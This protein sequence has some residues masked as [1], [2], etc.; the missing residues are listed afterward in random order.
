MLKASYV[1]NCWLIG[2]PRKAGRQQDL[3]QTRQASRLVYPYLS[4]YLTCTSSME[5]VSLYENSQVASDVT[6][7]SKVSIQKNQ[8]HQALSLGSDCSCINLDRGIPLL[9]TTTVSFELLYNWK[10]SRRLSYIK[11]CGYFVGFLV[12]LLTYHSWPSLVQTPLI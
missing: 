5:Y 2:H 10:T 12:L 3:L 6:I 8:Q 1:D 9:A 7:V 11:Q 4:M